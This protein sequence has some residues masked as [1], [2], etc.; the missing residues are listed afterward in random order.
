MQPHKLLLF[1]TA[2]LAF[3]LVACQKEVHS[4]LSDDGSIPDTLKNISVAALPGAARIT[5][6]LPDNA[7][8]LY[9][10]ADYENRP[11]IRREIKASFYNNSLIVD[12]FG[13]TLAHTINLYVVSRSERASRPVT[14][15]VKPLEPAVMTVFRSLAVREDFGGVNI[16]FRNE[17]KADIAI[18]TLT[19]DSLGIFG[20]TD[21]H[22]TSSPGSAYSLRGFAATKRA[23]GFFVKDRWGNQS[24][25]LRGEYTPLYEKLMDKSKFR[26]VD[27]PGDVGYGWGL[28]MPNLWNGIFSGYDMWHSAD[29]LD[30]M[31]MWITFDM[32]VTAQLSR[33]GLWQRQ[34]E[35]YLYAQNNLR[36]FEIW[37]S[38]NPPTDGSWNNWTKLIEHTVVKP[39]NLPIGQ[40][41][42][43]DLDAA[44]AGEQMDIPLTAPRVRYIR[45][46]ILKTWT[47]G[48]YAANI[49][50]MSF[51][52]NDQ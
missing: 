19:D 41:S 4:P 20:Q 52:G 48:G 51:W 29:K 38:V 15:S 12:G 18:V 43:E 49:A 2:L 3:G 7:G 21:I 24:D 46:K 50:E 33:I 16:T 23:F 5:Y 22:Y 31:P 10:R 42:Q 45:V 35:G 27:L 11:G 8:I 13:D 47:D 25:T 17:S 28:P 26:E 40:V 34:Q 32:G 14:I 6:T 37:G 39:S 30:G 44:A 1:F 9:V 36:Q